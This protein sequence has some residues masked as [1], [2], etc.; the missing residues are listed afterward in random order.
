MTFAEN[1]V[2]RFIT[3][4]IRKALNIYCVDTPC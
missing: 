4:E 3:T 2:L 1:Y